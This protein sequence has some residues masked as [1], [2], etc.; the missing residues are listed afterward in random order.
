MSSGELHLRRGSRFSSH[1]EEFERLSV[2]DI[3]INR[4]SSRGLGD[5]IMAHALAVDGHPFCAKHI[6]M[7]S[8]VAGRHR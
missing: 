4:G 6:T 3:N 7:N 8:Y 1:C 5:V 2:V